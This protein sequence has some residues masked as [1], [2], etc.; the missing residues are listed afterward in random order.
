MLKRHALLR[1][2]RT[3][4]MSRTSI[5][6]TGGVPSELLKTPDCETEHCSGKREGNEGA[7]VGSHLT[8]SPM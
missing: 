6:F 2:Q 7:A 1:P 5:Q 3:L 8:L 4:Q